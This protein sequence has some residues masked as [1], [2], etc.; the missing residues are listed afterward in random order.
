[1]REPADG[2]ARKSLTGLML[3]ELVSARVAA[4]SGSREGAA[5]GTASKSLTILA[6]MSS[7]QALPGAR[8]RRGSG[9]Q[10]LP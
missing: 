3:S 1:M 9:H 2:T 4:I 8:Q 10:R 6:N 5:D 7:W